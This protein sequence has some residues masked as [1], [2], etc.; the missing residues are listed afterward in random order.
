MSK[1]YV[2]VSL[3]S[4]ELGLLRV[5]LCRIGNSRA[6]S[7]FPPIAVMPPAGEHSRAVPN[8][9]PSSARD[10][11]ARAHHSGTPAIRSPATQCS[12][13]TELV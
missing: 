1:V 5:K 8:P 6:V 2:C 9:D 3:K 13:S 4:I 11:N 7:G 12:R 10:A